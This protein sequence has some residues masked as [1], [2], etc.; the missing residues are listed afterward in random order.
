MVSATSLSRFVAE[1]LAGQPLA[2][3]WTIA[4]QGAF[5]LRTG[6]RLWRWLRL[7]QGH[8]RLHL[9]RFG[10]PPSSM[11]HRAF[12]ATWAH[13]AQCFPED[14]DAHLAAFQEHTQVGLFG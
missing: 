9:C 11:D 2:E 4:T 5:H 1:L 14:R 13:L 3:A 8:L 12:T 6:L 10:E 7:S